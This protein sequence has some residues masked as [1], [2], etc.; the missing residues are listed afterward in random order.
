MR[1]RT[2]PLRIICGIV[3]MPEANIIA[4][5]GVAT[6]NINAQLAAKVIGTLNINGDKSCWIA[7][8]PMTGKNVAV[9]AKLLVNSVRN[10]TNAVVIR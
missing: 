4:L 7:I 6:G 9:V 1:L 10:M 5:G 3:S 8:A 2:T